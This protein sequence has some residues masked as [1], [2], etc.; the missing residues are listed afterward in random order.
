M[1]LILQINIKGLYWRFSYKKNI[2][3]KYISFLYGL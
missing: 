2:Y 1:H 3:N